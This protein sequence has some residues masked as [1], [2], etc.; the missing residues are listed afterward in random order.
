MGWR[1]RIAKRLGVTAAVVSI[2]VGRG[3]DGLVLRSG[4]TSIDKP[5]HELFQEFEDAREA[6]RKNPLARRLVGL[7][8]SYVV[9]NG[10]TL[11][12]EKRHLHNFIAEFWQVNRMELRVDEW[13]DELSRSGELFPILFTNPITG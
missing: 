10:I 8:T 6:W 4:G 13:S 9:G 11:G 7:I 1:E 2:P 5:W 12:S 3:D